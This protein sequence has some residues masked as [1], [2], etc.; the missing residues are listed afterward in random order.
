MQVKLSSERTCTPTCRASILTRRVVCYVLDQAVALVSDPDI[1]PAVVRTTNENDHVWTQQNGS[2][3]A[4][5]LFYVV[6][7]DITQGVIGYL[8]LAVVSRRFGRVGI[9]D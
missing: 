2:Y 9:L 5:N 3:S 1:V 8:N 7:G 6:P 4:W